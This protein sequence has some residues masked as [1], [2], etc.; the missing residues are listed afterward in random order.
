MYLKTILM[1]S[2]LAMLQMTQACDYNAK[3]GDG[4]L[5]Q[6]CA[7][8]LCTTDEQCFSGKCLPRGYFTK[9]G[10]C[11]SVAMDQP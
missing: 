3:A 5:G 2:A 1:M 9:E 7:N 8:E 6:L 10:V 11:D 4:S